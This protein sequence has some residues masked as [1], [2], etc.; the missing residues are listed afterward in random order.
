VNKII[1]FWSTYEKDIDT[2]YDKWRNKNIRLSKFHKLAL[3]S[4]DKLNNKVVLCRYQ[5]F[6]SDEAI[7][8]HFEYLDA[9]TIFPAKMAY[10]ALKRG[11]SIAH[12]ADAVRLNVASKINGIV[13]DMD[14]IVLR[15]L[16][17]LDSWYSSMPAKLTGGMAPRWGKSHPPLKIHNN[18]WS[19]K[20]LAS[21]PIKVSD[22][23][24]EDIENL[25]YKI[26]RTLIEPPKKSSKA[27]NYVLWSIKDIIKTDKQ[28]K[29]Y[30]PI[31]FC[32]LPAWLRKGNGYSLEDPSRLDGKTELFGYKMPSIKELFSKSYVIQH[33]FESAAHKQGG[34][35]ITSEDN[36]T[37]DEVFWTNLPENC[38]LAQESCYILGNNWRETIINKTI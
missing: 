22:R 20:A 38:L 35:G 16:P 14:A 2:T 32:P 11:H 33:F 9:D 5:Y 30:K 23:T 27:W 1:L 25:S 24:K 8:G 21:F 10:E 18:S 26:M 6:H 17:K 34:Y 36:K 19:G 28:G 31:Y 37:N 13:M 29:V 12:I 4:H 7:P 15:E 3:R